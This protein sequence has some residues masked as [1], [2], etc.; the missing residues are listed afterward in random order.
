MCYS[1]QGIVSLIDQSAYVLQSAGDWLA[2]DGP[3]LA[4]LGKLK[5]YTHHKPKHDSGLHLYK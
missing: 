1:Q 4:I 5:K 3:I 2:L